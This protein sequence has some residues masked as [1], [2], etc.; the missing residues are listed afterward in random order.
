MQEGAQHGGR[1]GDERHPA[2][3][4]LPSREEAEE[5]HAQNRAVG[6][7][8]DAED[9]V[10]AAV[11]GAV[12]EGED[13]KGHAGG[14]RR[15]DPAPD[16]RQGGVVV[17]LRRLQD[18]DREG[19]RQRRERTARRRV[20]ARQQADEEE[21]PDDGRQ[22]AVGGDEREDLVALF[23]ERQPGMVDVEVEQHAEHQEEE[24]HEDLTHGREQDVLLRVAR[25]RAAHVALHHVLPEARHGDERHDPRDEHLPEVAV[26]GR[27]VEKEDPRMGRGGHLAGHFAEREPQGAGDEE[28]RQHEARDQ[29]ARLEDVGADERADAAL[30]RVEPY[31]GHRHGGVEPEG[32]S[33][34]VE[35]EQ[36]HDGADDVDL[37]RS[38]EHLRH[39]EAPRP[40]GVRAGAE[41]VVE[42]LVERDEFQPVEG[43]DEQVGDDELPDGET[44]DHLHV[45]E[46]VGGHRARYRD[47]GH[48]RHRGADH[49]E[50][51]QVPRRAPVCGEESG[52]VGPAARNPGYDEQ[53]GDVPR[54]G[55]DY[56]GRCHAC[57]LNKPKA[58][59]QKKTT[60]RRSVAIFL[61]FR[62][63]GAITARTAAAGCESRKNGYL[64]G[65]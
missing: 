9:E 45:G 54:Q 14:H 3:A 37:Q 64:C 30:P 2:V 39:E 34:A 21:H 49:G 58:K 50:G 24:D 12:S 65:N 16:V 27:I 11:V 48:A 23:G 56:G 29:A 26:R 59:I 18:V 13:H 46:G 20:G 28:D 19:G 6:V 42:V 33:V 43:R 5:E 55:G 62:D 1:H 10:D 7:A 8:D 47:E 60:G 31:E 35:D 22:P 51:R 25:R 52:V 61:P 57:E 41:A 63:S 53:Q 40:G 4:D 17:A 38:A 36:L 15:V 32:Q 44:R